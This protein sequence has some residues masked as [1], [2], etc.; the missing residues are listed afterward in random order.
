VDWTNVANDG[1]DAVYQ[2]RIL[3]D[4]IDR[5]VA[6]GLSALALEGAKAVGKTATASRRAAQTFYLDDDATFRLLEADPTL[7][8]RPTS[9]LLDEWQRL[10]SVWDVVRRSVDDGAQPG[11]FFLTG[12]AT[13]QTGTHSG[14]G[15][16]VRLAMRPLSLLERGVVSPTVS[17][18]QLFTGD[19]TAL[20]GTSSWKLQDYVEEML[21]SGFPALRRY[22]GELRR[23]ELRSYVERIVDRELPDLLGRRSRNPGNV[24]RWLRAYAAATAT[25]SSLESIRNAATPGHAGKPTRLTSVAIHDALGDIFI[26]DSIPA[27]SPSFNHLRELGSSPKHHLVDP[28]LAA[29][30]LNLSVDRLLSP[31]A[32]SSTQ[33]NDHAFLG[34]LFESLV[35]QSVRVY[36]QAC[37]A[38]IGHLRTHRGEREVDLV[39]E[40]YDGR[41]IAIEVK[42]AG[43]VG[44]DDVRHLHWLRNQLGE[45]LVDALV[46]TTGPYAYR[47]ADGIGVVPASLIGP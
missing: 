1:G 27:W 14:A 11:R 38:D 21:A 35:A 24:L 28:A 23:M 10:P 6:Q 33:H 20:E 39:L 9:V 7:L 12:S 4:V 16:I 17:L 47:R 3:D 40:R 41:V 42:L 34:A 26:L 36:A 15:R 46:V 29:I 19:R 25:T 8:L 30:L 2:R 5:M 13:R 44:D 31:T 43:T 22:S 18:S 37:E 32:D 45:T